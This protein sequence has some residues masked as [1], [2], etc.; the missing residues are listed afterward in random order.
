MSGITD[1]AGPDGGGLPPEGA[2]TRL[3]VSEAWWLTGRNPITTKL[4]A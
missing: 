3:F 4:L 2:M 1:E